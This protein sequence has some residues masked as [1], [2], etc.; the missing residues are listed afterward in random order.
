MNVKAGEWVKQRNRLLPTIPRI[1]HPSAH[2]VNSSLDPWMDG[3]V[4]LVY[5]QDSINTPPQHQLG[6]E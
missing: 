1:D 3:K 2:H 5:R 6:S 4:S